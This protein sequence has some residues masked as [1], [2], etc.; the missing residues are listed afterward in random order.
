MHKILIADDEPDIHTVTKLS[1]KSLAR[2][3]GSIEFI[4]A[5]SGEA[6]LQALREQPDIGLVLLD[7]VMESEHA[8]LQVCRAIREDLGNQLVRIVLR[9]G[10]PGMAPEQQTIDGYDIDGYLS[11]AE[12]SSSRLYS[13]VRCALK[14]YQ[15]LV[16]LERHRWFLSAAHDCAVSLSAAK[17][18]EDMLRPVLETVLAICPAPLCALHLETFEQGLAP[19]H[20]F[21]YLAPEPDALLAQRAAEALRVRVQSDAARRMYEAGPLADGFFV[22]LHLHHELGHG[23][24]FVADYAPDELAQKTLILLAGHAQ[25]AI[26]ASLALRAARQ[27]TELIFEEAAI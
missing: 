24:L 26:Y 2:R 15:E 17:S 25:N 14:S 11:K 1:L 8:G 21:L 27:R 3:C 12:T 16:A 13:T 19:R 7:V 20:I 22:P 23:W 9:T 18:V 4:S 6:A 10:Q 5:S